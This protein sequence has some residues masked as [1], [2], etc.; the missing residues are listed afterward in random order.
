MPEERRCACEGLQEKLHA[1]DR[2]AEEGVRLR[3]QSQMCID[4]LHVTKAVAS[5]MHA[6]QPNSSEFYRDVV[7]AT[8]GVATLLAATPRC[9]LSTVM[10][11]TQNSRSRVPAHWPNTLHNLL[12]T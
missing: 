7:E 9:K 5:A 1:E 2:L 4:K 3:G 11:A 8:E 6:G 12:A 10:A